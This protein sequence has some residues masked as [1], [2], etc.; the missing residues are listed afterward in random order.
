MRRRS[1]LTSFLLHPNPPLARLLTRRQFNPIA[2]D[3]PL[4]S[5][6]LEL[7]RVGVEPSLLVVLLA[8]EALA[9]GSGGSLGEE[10]AGLVVGIEGPHLLETWVVGH[11]EVVDSSVPPC[12]LQRNNLAL[13]PAIQIDAPNEPYMH[14]EPPV[15]SAAVEA[16]EAAYLVGLGRG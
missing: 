10:T 16:H 7:S 2:P 12:S 11:V 1:S 5:P 8:Y 14:P 13:L 3:L 6:S 4:K 9:L 15:A